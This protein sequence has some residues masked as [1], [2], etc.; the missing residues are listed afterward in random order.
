[1]WTEVFS[2]REEGLLCVLCEE[3]N[4]ESHTVKGMQASVCGHSVCV[5]FVVEVV[6]MLV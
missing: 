3:R 1:M 5:V 6:P 4:A 2:Y